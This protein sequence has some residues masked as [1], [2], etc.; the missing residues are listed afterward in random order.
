M[1]NIINTFAG[2][3]F[4][5]VFYSQNHYT[6]L[7]S[8]GTPPSYLTK[9]IEDNL[10]NS[11]IVTSPYEK[12]SVRLL[13]MNLNRT[14]YFQINEMFSSGNV[15]YGDETYEYLNELLSLILK[16]NKIN[17]TINVNSFKSS[18]SNAFATDI[19]LIFVNLGLLSKIQNEAE[20]AF[21]L[22]HEL[23]HYM[24]RHNLE[25]QI[26]K[27][28]QDDLSNKK[29]VTA[30][31]KL[32]QKHQFS[33]RFELEADSLGMIYF[34]EAGYNPSNVLGVFDILAD[35][36]F[37]PDDFNPNTFFNYTSR[38]SNFEKTKY[39]SIISVFTIK[40]KFY[41]D[42]FSTHPQLDKRKEKLKDMT[43]DKIKGKQ[44]QVSGKFYKKAKEVADL[45]NLRISLLEENYLD[46][47]YYAIKCKENNKYDEYARIGFLRA[48]IGLFLS[49]IY[50]PNVN[51]RFYYKSGL[52][53]IE[54]EKDSK[55]KDI[56]AYFRMTNYQDLSKDIADMI[57]SLSFDLPDS[58]ELKSINNWFIK[59]CEDEG[60]VEVTDFQLD[61][62]FNE[63]K[64]EAT[65]FSY[66]KKFFVDPNIVV[67]DV[68]GK[69]SIDFKKTEFSKVRISKYI[70]RQ[71]KKQEM[72]INLS[73]T[74]RA[75]YSTEKA[76]EAGLINT[77]VREIFSSPLQNK[78]PPVDYY[79]LQN[80]CKEKDTERVVFTN[81]LTV[82]D[83]RNPL[84]VG[85]L[86]YM[87][88]TIPLAVVLDIVPSAKTYYEYLDVDLMS[89][90]KSKP[91]SL[92]N[93]GEVNLPSVLTI[94]KSKF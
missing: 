4:L 94:Y 64:F 54:L 65:T 76:N 59:W 80:M 43:P 81:G 58:E 2:L 20:L 62:N 22:C 61:S 18:F 78:M 93:K 89:G 40:E 86:Y 3:C 49:K 55:F 39:D 5:S 48:H 44:S 42:K 28:N 37:I 70:N 45:E 30:Y 21:V 11:K 31:D 38:T 8:K 36:H 6:P 67:V 29:A 41:N 69:S 74:D 33:Q 90:N 56:L 68:R 27:Y 1:K 12:E 50:D 51:P 53:D 84:T 7:Q 75:N 32:V 19:G 92:N 83:K 34:L 60:K 79:S 13:E 85:I 16:K 24:L 82:Y 87:M 63:Q 25:G 88:V 10:K 23:S 52:T 17:E 57:V 35:Q 9:T 26:V 14:S 77:R 46:A 91:Y 71:N 72:F 73:L 15:I 66:Q 47:I